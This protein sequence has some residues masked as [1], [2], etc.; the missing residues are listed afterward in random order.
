VQRLVIL[1]PGQADRIVFRGFDRLAAILHRGRRGLGDGIVHRAVVI[2]LGFG[3]GI[4]VRLDIDLAEGRGVAAAIDRLQLQRD[5]FCPG[6][7]SVVLPRHRGR[8]GAVVG[9]DRGAQPTARR[10]TE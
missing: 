5:R 9:P 8:F 2:E 6:I 7:V 4:R 3:I 10:A 1:E